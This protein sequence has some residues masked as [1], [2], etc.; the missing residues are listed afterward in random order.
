[1]D[2]RREQIVELVEEH[3]PCSVRHVFYRA[4]VA[5]MPGITKND[6]G[7]NKVQ[8]AMLE[9]RRA[10]AIP[11][12]QIVDS[13][14]WMRK[15]QTFN[16]IDAALLT[17]AWTYRRDLWNASDYRVEV[18]CESDSIASTIFYVTEEWDVALMVCRGFSSET[19]AYNAAENWRETESRQPVVLYV[20]DHDPAGLDIETTLKDQLAEF[21]EIEP[22]WYRL[23]VTWAQISELQLPG[24]NPKRDYGFPIA[25]EAEALPPSDLRNLV[26]DAIQEFVD[27]RQLAILREWEESER[28]VL[29][30]MAGRS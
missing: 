1:M 4:V 22:W 11:Y 25:V 30:K 3:G 8:R 5:E 26:H 15:L 28:T 13:T 2:Q 6:S 9:L 10:G 21:A 14:R 29:F 17:T 7:Y 16:S 27:H 23:G 12:A 20:G 19:F 18:W 24:T